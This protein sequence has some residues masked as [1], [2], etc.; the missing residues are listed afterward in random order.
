[1]MVEMQCGM[2]AVV[3]NELWDSGM[4]DLYLTVA[5]CM[6]WCAVECGSDVE[7]CAEMW[8]SELKCGAMWN[9]S[10]NFRHGV[11]WW[12]EM[13]VGG[14]LWCNIMSDVEY[15]GPRWYVL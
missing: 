5:M 10:C 4:C 8:W 1:M 14:R 12:C 11:M 9:V 13:V 6:A 7:W 3:W 2:C 15:G